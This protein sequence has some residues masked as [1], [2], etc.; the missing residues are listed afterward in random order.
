MPTDSKNA[1]IGQDELLAKINSYTIDTLPHAIL[2]EGDVGC[3]KHT[4]CKYI[5]E[6]LNLEVQELKDNSE[7]KDLDELVSN[8][9]P[10]LYIIDFVGVIPKFQNSILK[11]LEEPPSN[12]FF[13]CLCTSRKF[14]LPTIQN[15]CV[16]MSFAKY[17]RDIL[18]L[19][20]WD[21]DEMLAELAMT[22]YDTP[23]EILRN[24]GQPLDK[25]YSLA[26]DVLNRIGNASYP[27]VLS[28]SDKIAF[29]NE[30]GK[31]DLTTFIKALKVEAYNRIVES[32]NE[33]NIKLYRSI[34]DM[35]QNVSMCISKQRAFEGSLVKMKRSL[36]N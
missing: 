1:I 24:R 21:Y 30:K 17:K 12:S 20:A 2:L 7:R 11:M 32:N 3:G 9:H 31:F 27:N 16:L 15:R 18:E 26:I 14:I 25:I 36:C 10:A 5:G 6:K 23:G 22:L 8:P 28:I 4:L 29:K 19:F 34:V 35:E 13:V 33:I